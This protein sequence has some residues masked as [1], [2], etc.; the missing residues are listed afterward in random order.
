MGRALCDVDKVCLMVLGLPAEGLHPGD[1][2]PGFSFRE[3]SNSSLLA[4]HLLRTRPGAFRGRHFLWQVCLPAG[5]TSRM[6]RAGKRHLGSICGCWF[7]HLEGEVQKNSLT[8]RVL[9]KAWSQP[10]GRKT[11]GWKNNPQGHLGWVIGWSVK[12][13]LGRY[14]Q[15]P[16]EEFPCCCFLG[17]LEEGLPPTRCMSERLWSKSPGRRATP[18]GVPSTIISVPALL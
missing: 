4:W 1:H 2:S 15:T 5:P 16:S 13:R 9:T 17:C 18:V 11:P 8:Q 12:K 10:I 6:S 7:A 14:T 3:V